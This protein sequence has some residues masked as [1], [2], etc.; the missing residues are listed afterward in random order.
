[1]PATL[2]AGAS[3]LLGGAL[4][5]TLDAQGIEVRR[6]VRRAAVGPQEIPW[7]P[8]R[9]VLDPGALDGADAVINLAGRRVAPGRWTAAAR[10]E[11]ADSRIRATRLLVETMG[12]ARHRP[13]VFISA[14]AI[15][16]YGDRG[17]QVLTE[18]AGPGRGFM[19]DVAVAWEQEA[20]RAPD[21]VRV[22]C[23]RFG[24]VLAHGGFLAPLL[25]LFRLGLGGPLGSGR[26]WW[27][28][29]HVED[30]VA[31]VLFALRT[32]S[33]AGPV[34][35]VGPHPVPN[36]EFAQALARAVRR[37]ALLRAPAFALRL[38]L[39]RQMADELLLSSQRV[40]P[41]R[42]QAHGFRFRWTELEPALRDLVGRR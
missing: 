30:L 26:Q 4:A 23:T 9:G 38:A 17:D 16:F 41:A 18:E 24:L 3:G 25:A 2:I 28:W 39:G 36:R 37:P 8:A 27:S 14:S 5:A 11:I 20:Q 1:M 34:N 22:V 13:P 21:G 19:A 7:D 29:V 15:G 42:L 31:A 35:V 40:L 12:R 6:L 32:P 33:L 10:R